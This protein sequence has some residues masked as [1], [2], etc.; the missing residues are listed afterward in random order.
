VLDNVAIDKEIARA[1]A[2][3]AATPLDTLARRCGRA[4][5]VILDLQGWRLNLRI[6]PALQPLAAFATRSAEFAGPRRSPRYACTN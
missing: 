1:N 6:L 2:I 5:K 3:I 4:G